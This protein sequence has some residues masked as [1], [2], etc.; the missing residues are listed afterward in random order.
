MNVDKEMSE[1]YRGD[2]SVDAATLRAFAEEQCRD[3]EAGMNCAT[4]M[5]E[6]A[7]GAILRML[8]AFANEA[9]DRH[10]SPLIRWLEDQVIA[11]AEARDVALRERD[12]YRA[13]SEDWYEEYKKQ[14]RKAQDLMRLVG[15][16]GALPCGWRVDQ[17][18]TN[19]ELHPDPAP[20]PTSP[21]CLD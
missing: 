10:P 3:C 6:C 4:D 18:C 2:V 16:K 12:Q 13:G 15:E 7:Y 17:R 5:R 1:R 19:P 20:T 14:F 9:K 8:D 11:Q 21:E